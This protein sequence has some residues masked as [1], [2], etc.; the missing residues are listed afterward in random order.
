MNIEK[1]FEK[2]SDYRKLVEHYNLLLNI[3][4]STEVYN[5]VNMLK[6]EA[7]QKISFLEELYVNQELEDQNAV[8]KQYY[9]EGYKDGR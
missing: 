8:M 4:K 9:I 2:I 6:K 3:T 5:Y 1:A 7:R